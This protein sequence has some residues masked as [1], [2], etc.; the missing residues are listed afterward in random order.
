MPPNETYVP[1]SNGRLEQLS[2]YVNSVGYDD[3]WLGQI[4]N[5]LDEQ[6]VA[7]ETLVIFTGDHG[8]SLPENDRPASYYNPNA[9]CNHVPL[10]LSH[11]KLP[12]MDVAGSVCSIEILPTVLLRETGSLSEAA[13]IAAG[14]LLANY[15]GQS[16][17]RTLRNSATVAGKRMAAESV[18]AFL[19]TEDGVLS[20]WQFVVMNP[21]RAIVGIRDKQRPHWRL[22][23]PVIKNVEWRFNDLQD[24]PNDIHPVEA[25]DFAAFLADVEKRYSITEAKWAEEAAFIVRWFIDENNKRWQYG[26]YRPQD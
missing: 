19:D 9:G 24:E 18:P 7:D 17:I 4:V 6:G 21:G 8:I 23:A 26:Q 1:L 2:H 16:L 13:S 20:N 3:R 25:F 11:P 5:L 15:E 10:V 12:F 22:V 14:D